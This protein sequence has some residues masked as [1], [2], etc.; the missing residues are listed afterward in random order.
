MSTIKVKPANGEDDNSY[1]EYH[2]EILRYFVPL[3]GFRLEVRMKSTDP[4]WWGNQKDSLVVGDL[5]I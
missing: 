2:Y 3:G 5:T 4:A 1:G